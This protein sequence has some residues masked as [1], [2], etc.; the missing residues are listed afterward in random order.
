MIPGRSHCHRGDGA[1]SGDFLSYLEDWVEKG[2]APDMMIGYHPDNES[3][4]RNYDNSMK[5]NTSVPEKYKFSRPHYPY[6]QWAKYRGKG[7]PNDYRNF[8]AVDPESQ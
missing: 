7:D 3:R 4:D 2:E 8:E 6:P 5:A 1:S